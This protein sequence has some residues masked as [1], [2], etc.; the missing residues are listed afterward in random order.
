MNPQLLSMESA[1]VLLVFMRFFDSIL[2]LLL[3]LMVGLGVIVDL[4]TMAALNLLNF[5]NK[6]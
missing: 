6:S 4:K 2:L 1:S 5:I 3:K